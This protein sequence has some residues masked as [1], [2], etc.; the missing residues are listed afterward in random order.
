MIL[1]CLFFKDFD[2]ILTMILG[3]IL[4]NSKIY[5]VFDIIIKGRNN[6]IYVYLSQI[7][8]LVRFVFW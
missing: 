8:Y 6:P 1:N 7:V 4:H 3:M 5:D 2:N